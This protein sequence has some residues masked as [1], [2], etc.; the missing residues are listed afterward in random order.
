[1]AV[2]HKGCGS[3]QSWSYFRFYPGTILEPDTTS[4]PVRYTTLVWNHQVSN[5]LNNSVIMY[6]RKIHIRRSIQGNSHGLS[7]VMSQK[8][9][10]K[11][12]RNLSQDSQ[13]TA[14]FDHNTSW[15]Q[16]ITA[17]QSSSVKPGQNNDP[18]IMQVITDDNS[19]FSWKPG[20]LVKRKSCITLSIIIFLM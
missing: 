9:L 1:M 17:M 5:L 4:I 12:I 16:V 20:N 10:R 15:R 13:L 14:G 19:L 3:K 18:S 7:K 8:G 2:N 11:T 6:A